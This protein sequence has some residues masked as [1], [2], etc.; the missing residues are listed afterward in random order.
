[1]P[2][3]AG[4]TSPSNLNPDPIPRGDLAN[5]L[6]TPFVM[7]NKKFNYFCDFLNLHRIEFDL[8][9]HYARAYGINWFSNHLRI[10]DYGGPGCRRLT[11]FKFID[12]N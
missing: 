11:F 9:L 8:C 3:A 6:Q 1:M 2:E 7:C 5:K 12:K 4:V 10:T